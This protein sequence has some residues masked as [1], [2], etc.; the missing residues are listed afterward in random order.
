MSEFPNGLFYTDDHEWVRREEHGTCRVGI[1][2][3]AQDELGDV[4]FV[5]LPEVGDTVV[6]GDEM[7]SI[8]SVKTVAEIYA[9][10]GGEVVAVNQALEE[11]PEKVNAD[12]YGEGWLVELRYADESGLEKLMDAEAYKLIVAGG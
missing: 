4:V 5:D 1:T 10:V 6:A 7:G 9:P 2:D 11:A 12:A 8:E 3:Y